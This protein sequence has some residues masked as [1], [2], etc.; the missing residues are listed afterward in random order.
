[1]VGPRPEV[2]KWVQAYPERWE[3]VLTVKPGIT[4]NASIEFRD[5]EDILAHSSDPEKVYREEIL[6]RKLELYEDYVMNVS[7]K[8]DLGIILK[9]IRGIL[10][11]GRS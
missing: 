5:E 7:L 11:G 1:M 4:D 8:R 6:P 3:R 9:T 10:P 2:R